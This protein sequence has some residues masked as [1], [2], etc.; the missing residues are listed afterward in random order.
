MGL[1]MA[2]VGTSNVGIEGE[3]IVMASRWLGSPIASLDTPPLNFSRYPPKGF[4]L[5]HFLRNHFLRG[6]EL[7]S[8]E[9]LL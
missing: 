1:E 9:G 3:R 5:R 2:T 8:R 4:D 7:Y 6:F